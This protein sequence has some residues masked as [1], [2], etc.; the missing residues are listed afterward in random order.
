M[1]KNKIETTETQSS[2]TENGSYFASNLE[3][4]QKFK[5]QQFYIGRRKRSLSENLKRL[6][7]KSEKRGTIKINNLK[8]LVKRDTKNIG[9]D[10][11]LNSRMMVYFKEAE[12]LSK[13]NCNF[14]DFQ[15]NEKMGLRFI[16]VHSVKQRLQSL[17]QL[18]MNSFEC[19][20]SKNIEKWKNK[21]FGIQKKIE[22]K[23]WKPPQRTRS[24]SSKKRY[25]S[26]TQHDLLDRAEYLKKSEI[27]KSKNFQKQKLQ[28]I[29]A[30]IGTRTSPDTLLDQQ[31]SH[32]HPFFH[33]Q[34]K[35]LFQKIK[36][37]QKSRF[38]KA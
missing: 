22:I 12:N 29:I 21:I 2:D 15:K 11:L 3:K 16:P 30:K 24:T 31:E 18:K 7:Y 25:Y 14:L 13:K 33:T 35:T 38:L 1:I 26:A 17:K 28:K 8:K 23:E 34:P 10:D 20:E 5:K 32:Y 9:D 4:V 36:K 19:Q 37:H 6:R 27:Q